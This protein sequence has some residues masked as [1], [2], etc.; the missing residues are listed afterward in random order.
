LGKLL[1]MPGRYALV[2]LPC[3]IQG[4]RKAQAA[5]PPL[6]RRVVLALGL[7]CGTTCTPRGTAIGIRRA[8][9]DPNDVAGIAYR[10]EGWP[11]AFRLTLRS[12]SVV[13]V[14]YPD[15]LD[16]WFAAHV[17]QRC[18]VCPDGTNELADVAIGDAWVERFQSESGRGSLSPSS[19]A[20]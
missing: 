18:L 16:P 10:G 6:R 4:L 2:G 1:G 7:F 9:V 5:I 8:G 11:G 12:G 15:Y 20:S 14:P 13:E 17:P 3:Q 19:Q